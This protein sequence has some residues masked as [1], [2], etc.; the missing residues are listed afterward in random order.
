MTEITMRLATLNDLR[1]VAEMFDDYRQFYE[2]AADLVLATTFISDRLQRKESVILLAENTRCEAMGFCQ[3]YPTFCSVEAKPIFTLYDLFVKPTARHLGVGKLLM[4]A[5]E[6]QAKLGG[7]VR[8]DL[9]TGKTNLPA[10]S[11]YS[12]LG[13]KRDE[14]FFAYNK[15][16]V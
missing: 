11:L 15:Q 5:A 7:F 12:S 4:L 1:S 10:Q 9:T 14:V 3:L 16:V 13:W 2:K 8:M 6:Q